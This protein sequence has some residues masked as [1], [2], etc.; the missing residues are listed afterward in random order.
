MFPNREDFPDY[1]MGKQGSRAGSHQ[2]RKLIGTTSKILGYCR[3]GDPSLEIPQIE[4]AT[5]GELPELGPKTPRPQARFQGRRVSIH[6]NRSLCLLIH[7]RDEV[8]EA[9]GNAQKSRLSHPSFHMEAHR[10]GV[11]TGIQIL[12]RQ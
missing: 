8:A 12:D 11:T 9:L 4:W 2:R 1:A 6:S 5:L 7:Y 10:A 3:A